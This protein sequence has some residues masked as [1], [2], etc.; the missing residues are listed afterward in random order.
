MI[1]QLT[2]LAIALL[3]VV[4]V[5]ATG[6]QAYTVSLF[7][8]DSAL[9]ALTETTVNDVAK[10]Y[11]VYNKKEKANYLVLQ[12]QDKQ[13][14]RY[15]VSEYWGYSATNSTTDESVAFR[16]VDGKE[17]KLIG[18]KP[19]E[20]ALYY[21]NWS[22]YLIYVFLYDETY[23]LD[24]GDGLIDLKSKKYVI[25]NIDD[26]CL[27]EKLENSK[28]SMGWF[29]G[30]DSATDERRIVELAQSCGVGK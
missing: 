7:Q 13:E 17:Y 28:K 26:E 2:I 4:E 10:V 25:N 30:K 24:Y 3:T 19:G 22:A 8:Y 16:Y 18:G 20:P 6:K 1:R 23:L 14:A 29:I 9:S 27:K 12:D 5:H 21:R 11:T 15:R